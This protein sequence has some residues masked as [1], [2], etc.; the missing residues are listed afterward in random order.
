MLPGWL[1]WAV[2]VICVLEGA[3]YFD[4]FVYW[5]GWCDRSETLV[6]HGNN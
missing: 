2:I 4:N 6:C 5:A 3:R 1:K